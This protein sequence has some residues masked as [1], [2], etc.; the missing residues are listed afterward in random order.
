MRSWVGFP[1]T[2]FIFEKRSVNTFEFASFT[3]FAA[4]CT[5]REV[6]CGNRGSLGEATHDFPGGVESVAF[7]PAPG[8]H[9]IPFLVNFPVACIGMHRSNIFPDNSIS[10][11][12]PP[13]PQRIFLPMV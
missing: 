3:S 9:S 5:G 12:H 1:N 8:E 7:P 10:C 11:L 6:K 13:Q 2:A 4:K